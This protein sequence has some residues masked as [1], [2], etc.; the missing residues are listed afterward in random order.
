M[1][2]NTA[3]D[4]QVLI[5]FW[6]KAFA[7][8]EEQ[9]AE[10]RNQAAENWKDLAPSEKLF[11]AAG[12][13]GQKKKVLDFGCGDAWAG[14]I[15]AKSGCTDVTAVD[16]APGA[17]QAAN[18]YAE[19]YGVEKS[20]H[21]VCGTSEW[22][23][24]VASDTFDGLICSNVLDVVPPETAEA[25]LRESAR[26]ITRDACVIIGLNYYLSPEAAAARDIELTDGNRL[27]MDGVLRL[28]SRT[29]EEWAQIFSPW[30]TVERL[31]QF[32]WPG[33]AKETRRLFWLRKREDI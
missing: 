2:E 1:L 31:E 9:Q 28:V 32:A 19:V 6:D 24:I 8:S 26:I 23:E 16:A 10:A 13:L 22:L 27:Y 4:N 5:D 15:A 11:R 30:Y 7:L 20:I 29:D 12:S 17:V 3:K 14:I 18:L 21:A 25:I 33:E